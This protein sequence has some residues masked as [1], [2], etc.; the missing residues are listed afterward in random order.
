M[1]TIEDEY[2]DNDAGIKVEK[3]DLIAVA[4]SVAPE[5]YQGV[6]A[7]EQIQKVDAITLKNLRT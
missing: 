5:K 1:I 7:T 4:L 3:A 2:N 6:M